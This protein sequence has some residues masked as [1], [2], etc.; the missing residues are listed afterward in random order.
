MLVGRSFLARRNPTFFHTIAIQILLL[1]DSLANLLGPIVCAHQANDERSQHLRFIGSQNL[2]FPVL[3]HSVSVFLYVL[4]CSTTLQN[5]SHLLRG[6]VI[7][8]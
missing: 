6:F 7:G 8:N 4:I 3:F 5:Q 1:R 2:R